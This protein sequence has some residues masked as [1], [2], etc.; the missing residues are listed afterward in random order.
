MYAK[1][2][3]I[4]SRTQPI[5]RPGNQTKR[6]E[7]QY[8]V[9]DSL[10]QLPSTIAADDMRQLVAESPSRLAACGRLDQV[11]RHNNRGRRNPITIGTVTSPPC[12]N[13]T[14]RFKPQRVRQAASCS[15]QSLA[16]PLAIAAASAKPP[17]ARR[18]VAAQAWQCPRGRAQAKTGTSHGCM[19]VAQPRNVDQRETVA[20]AGEGDCPDFCVSKNGTVPFAATGGAEAACAGELRAAGSSSHSSIATSV[21]AS[22]SGCRSGVP[23]LSSSGRIPL[24]RLSGGLLGIAAGGSSVEGATLAATAQ[25]QQPVLPAAQ[26][27]RSAT[28]PEAPGPR[29]M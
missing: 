22:E 24:L 28:A 1:P 15:S 19:A 10:Q 9:D 7:P 21:V 3:Q 6:M 25:L 13:S 17:R 11:G 20:G 8:G 5:R 12:R 14:S 27:M 16:S 18:S 29:S 26:D 4:R 2:S 23:P